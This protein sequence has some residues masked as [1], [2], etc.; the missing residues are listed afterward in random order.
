[1]PGVSGELKAS[2]PPRSAGFAKE[3]GVV[4]AFAV[5]GFAAPR[6]G[7]A[8]RERVSAS[9]AGWLAS[10]AARGSVDGLAWIMGRL[11]RR[12]TR[13]RDGSGKQVEA[14][15]EGRRG[16]IRT[17]GRHDTTRHEDEP[18]GNRQAIAVAAARGR[19]AIP[20]PLEKAGEFETDAFPTPVRAGSG[21]TGASQPG[22]RIRPARPARGEECS[23][24]GRDETG[25]PAVSTRSEGCP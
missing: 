5:P 20:R 19:P 18:R 12:A 24:G 15:S 6:R 11:R 23:E 10:A 2:G 8:K 13:R 17:R 21:S 7:G 9:R 25:A 14:A 22:T 3:P 4:A 1:M 16:R